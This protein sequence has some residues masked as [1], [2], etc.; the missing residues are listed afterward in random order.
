M[1]KKKLKK[2][3]DEFTKLVDELRRDLI[4]HQE[5]VI[6]LRD[7]VADLRHSLKMTDEDIIL[8]LK[9]ADR[10]CADASQVK[11]DLE[12]L[13]GCLDLDEARAIRDIR[14]EVIESMPEPP[15]K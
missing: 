15:A 5:E 9:E 12:T 10:A 14:R 3:V 4:N 8:A 2:L 7:A 13:T 1:K 6:G 11:R